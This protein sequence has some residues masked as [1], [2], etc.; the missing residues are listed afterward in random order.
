MRKALVMLL[1]FT[2]SICCV[3]SAYA[4]TLNDVFMKFVYGS[5]GLLCVG[6]LGCVAFIVNKF[7]TNVHDIFALIKD[8]QKDVSDIKV[9]CAGNHG[10]VKNDA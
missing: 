5:L 8:M 10:K 1:A 7:N 2:V 4:D 6:F 9:N 3:S